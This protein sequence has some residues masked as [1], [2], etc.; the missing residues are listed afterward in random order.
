MWKKRMGESPSPAFWADFLANLNA[1]YPGAILEKKVLDELYG[2]VVDE[3]RNGRQVHV[4]IRQLCSCDDGVTV[5]PSKGAALRLEKHRGL[6]RP[7]EAA[8]RGDVFG[9][10]QLRDAGTVG[11]LAAKLSMVDARLRQNPRSSKEAQLL[12]Q[13]R[14]LE[15]QIEAA[16][17]SAYWSVPRPK[18]SSEDSTVAPT[19]AKKQ[20]PKKKG[21]A[22]RAR[23]SGEQP[24]PPPSPPPPPLGPYSDELAAI[25]N[26]PGLSEDEHAG[27]V[28]TMLSSLERA[29][30]PVG[31]LDFS[32]LGPQKVDEIEKA[33]LAQET[34]AEP[35]VAGDTRRGEV[36]ATNKK[37]VLKQWFRRNA[38][39][40]DRLAQAVLP[41]TARNPSEP[42][43]VRIRSDQAPVM[44]FQA[45]LKKGD[46]VEV[47]DE[48]RAGGEVH[49]WMVPDAKAGKLFLPKTSG[50]VVAAEQT[51]QG[52]DSDITDDLINELSG[53]A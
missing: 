29:K 48:V 12:Q 45:G 53:R 23:R 38:D 10:D 2:L 3:W 9:L 1:I 47:M 24:T 50:E 52:L 37:K 15:Q 6:A 44:R 28:R 49:G 30:L 19:R 4:I 5:T 33:L 25:K 31:E 26:V 51:A 16:R 7:P 20:A 18:A 11:R 32:S 41:N 39:A 27:L 8:Q 42:L 36:R 22:T 35:A 14:D 40:L 17:E 34:T 46:V 13:R 43:R 21:K